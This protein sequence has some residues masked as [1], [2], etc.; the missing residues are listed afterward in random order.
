MK[1]ADLLAMLDDHIH[2]VRERPDGK[3]I[4]L[5][6][7]VASTALLLVTEDYKERAQARYWNGWQKRFCYRRFDQA[8]DAALEWDGEGDPPGD[9]IKDKSPGQDR[10]NP[11]FNNPDF[12]KDE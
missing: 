2:V 8:L 11:R 4:A 3:T 10:L 7:M 5:T 1:A 6:R 9:W 12:L